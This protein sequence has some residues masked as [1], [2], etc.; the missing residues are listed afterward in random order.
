MANKINNW[1]FGSD[2]EVFLVDRETSEVVSAIPFVMGDKYNPYQIPGLPEGCMIQTD[3]IMV[4]Y[5]I[6]PT[7]DPKEFFSLFTACREYTESIIPAQLRVNVQ[8]S[9]MM[10][11]KYLEDPQARR[12]G[13]EPDFNAWLNGKRNTA[14]KA[15]T[16]MRTAGKIVCRAI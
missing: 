13:C 4:E 14:P 5:C 3:N 1:L 10:D 8:A 16:N 7:R 6:P 12:F 2:P 9:A 15:N 11:P